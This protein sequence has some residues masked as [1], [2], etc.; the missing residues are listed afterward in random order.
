MGDCKN[1]PIGGSASQKNG[2]SNKNEKNGE[3]GESSEETKDDETNVQ[4]NAR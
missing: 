1:A 2:V 3:L 4:L